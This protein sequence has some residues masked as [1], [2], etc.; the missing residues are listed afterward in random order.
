MKPSHITREWAAESITEIHEGFSAVTPDTVLATV[1]TLLDSIQEDAF[2]SE[3]G[4]DVTVAN[5]IACVVE[6]L[7]DRAEDEPVAPAPTV[8]LEA[9][10][11]RI[12]S[13]AQIDDIHHAFHVG[14]TM[15][16]AVKPDATVLANAIA[17]WEAN[18][19]DQCIAFAQAWRTYQSREVTA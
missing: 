3:T 19:T 4:E 11:V 14:L 10:P 16:E 2:W 17:T 9:F 5:L 12:R 15:A 8:S 6:W 7:A 13:Q 1:N 18:G